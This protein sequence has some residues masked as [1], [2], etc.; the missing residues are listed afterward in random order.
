[1]IDAAEGRPVFQ[2]IQANDYDLA[3]FWRDDGMTVVET[4]QRGPMSRLSVPYNCVGLVCAALCIR[5]PWIITPH[6]LYR[7]LRRAA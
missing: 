2:M 1:M 4:R 6:Q 7:H 5:A 3:G